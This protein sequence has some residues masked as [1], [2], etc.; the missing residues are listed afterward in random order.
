MKAFSHNSYIPSLDYFDKVMNSIEGFKI[1]KS[2]L[3]LRSELMQDDQAKG[4]ETVLKPMCLLGKPGVGKTEIVK[5]FAK[6]LRRPLV[7]I[8]M[9]GAIDTKD[10]EGTP[11]TYQ[12]P[13]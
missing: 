1:F 11:P 10:I 4:I 9:G 13:N 2:E 6:A 8:S 7:I 5:T 12:S 3:R